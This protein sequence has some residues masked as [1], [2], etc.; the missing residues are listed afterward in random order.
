MQRRVITAYLSKY[1]LS[2]FEVAVALLDRLGQLAAELEQASGEA[3]QLR[4]FALEARKRIEAAPQDL[5]LAQLL[6]TNL[7]DTVRD[8]WFAEFKEDTKNRDKLQPY[9]KQIENF[10]SYKSSK[11]SSS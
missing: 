8:L 2:T 3:S 6:L 4:E 10:I 11:S 5:A 9:L 1:S 7:R